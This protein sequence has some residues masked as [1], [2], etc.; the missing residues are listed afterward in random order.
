MA[1]HYAM[2][3]KNARTKLKRVDAKIEALTKKEEKKRLDI[4][5]E[6][7]LHAYNI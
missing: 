4:L 5:A 3:H 1:K 7:P 2:R 6:A